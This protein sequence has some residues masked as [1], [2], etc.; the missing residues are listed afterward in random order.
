[1][2]LGECSISKI[3]RSL[4]LYREDESWKLATLKT[5]DTKPDISDCELIVSMFLLK[6]IE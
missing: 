2:N 3:E 1:M 5:S 6:Y 4:I